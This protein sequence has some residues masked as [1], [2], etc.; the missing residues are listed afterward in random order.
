MPETSVPV[1]AT[2]LA[3][4]AKF[5]P[6]GSFWIESR[7]AVVP[8]EVFV[9]STTGA[10]AVTTT[11]SLTETDSTMGIEVVAPRDNGWFVFWAFVKPESET[12]RL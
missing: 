2:V 8:I 6:S 9:V 7:D 11:S 5:R 4:E 12:D 3:R 1:P 10:S